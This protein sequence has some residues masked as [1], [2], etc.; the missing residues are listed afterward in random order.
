[1]TTHLP[2]PA[3]AAA[4]FAA[5]ALF[6]IG[7]NYCVIGAVRGMP[8]ACTAIAGAVAKAESSAPLCPLH[9]SKAKGGPASK[10]QGTASCCMTLERADAPEL[11]RFDPA[12]MP[13]E[14]FALIAASLDVEAPVSAQAFVPPDESPPAPAWQNSA[15]AGRAPPA[16]A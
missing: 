8:M 14:A 16:L 9:A 13:F 6:L 7:S 10:S 2:R 4:T 3:R 15:H 1:V 12:P 11:P 5:L